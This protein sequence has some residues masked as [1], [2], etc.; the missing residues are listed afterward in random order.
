MQ[1]IRRSFGLKPREIIET[2]NLLRPIYQ[3]TAAYGHFGRNDPDF[4]W[5]RTDKKEALRAVAGRLRAVGSLE[6]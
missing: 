5:E 1:A 6:S 3:K 2:L 4:T